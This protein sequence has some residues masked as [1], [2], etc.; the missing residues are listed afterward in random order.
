MTKAQKHAA[1]GTWSP[2]AR[3]KRAATFAAKRAKKESDAEVKVDKRTARGL[4]ST[5]QVGDTLIYLKHAAEDILAEFRNGVSLKSL[6]KS[7]VLV[8]LAYKELERK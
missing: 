8:L 5:N 3:K 6:R 4:R 1:N 7:Q 2:A